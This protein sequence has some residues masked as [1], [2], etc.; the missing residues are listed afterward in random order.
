MNPKK[1]YLLEGADSLWPKNE[2]LPAEDGAIG[3]HRHYQQQPLDV[4]C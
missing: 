4:F 1:Q 2:R 3:D